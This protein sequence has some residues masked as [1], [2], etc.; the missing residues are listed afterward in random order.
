MKV[1]AD[2]NIWLRLADTGALQHAE[3]KQCLVRLLSMRARLCL[4]PQ[5]IVE[6]W[7]VATRPID[8]NGLGWT[9]E[10]TALEINNIRAQFI[11]LPETEFIFE[12]WLELVISEQIKGKR[13][14][15]ARLAAQLSV[16]G[17]SHLITFNDQD[18][19]KFS[20]ISILRPKDLLAAEAG[21]QE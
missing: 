12:R 17:I 11:L 4:V 15:D 19:A 13:V 16:H 2:T 3:V 8:A 5:N 18:F 21:L 20:W 7:A 9:T 14:H 1:L 6:F 10:K